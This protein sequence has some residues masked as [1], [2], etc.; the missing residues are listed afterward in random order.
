MEGFDSLRIKKILY[1]PASS[2]INV[3][4]E[5]GIRDEQGVG[6]RFRVPLKSI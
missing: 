3:I 6:E 2:E 1:L 4:L 5:C